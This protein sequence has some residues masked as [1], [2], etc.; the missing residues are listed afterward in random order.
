MSRRLALPL[1]LLLAALMAPAAAAAPR[2]C[3]AEDSH[4]YSNAA[5][6]PNPRGVTVTHLEAKINGVWREPQNVCVSVRFETADPHNRYIQYLIWNSAGFFFDLT[7][8]PAMPAG[9]PVSLGLQMP[10]DA[11]PVTTA[12]QYRDGIAGFGDTSFAV[13]GKTAPWT[14]VDSAYNEDKT[15]GSGVTDCSKGFTTF[16]STFGGF[17]RI[18]SLNADGSPAGDFNALQGTFMEGNGTGSP[19]VSVVRDDQRDVSAVQVHMEG[20]GDDDPSTLEGHFRAFVAPPALS[21]LGLPGTGLA[22]AGSFL[23]RLMDIRDSKRTTAV[24]GDYELVK[25]DDLAFEPIAGVTFPPLPSGPGVHGVI[26]GADF[27]Y[28]KHDLLVERRKANVAAFNRCRHAKRTPRKRGTKI[29]CNR[30]SGRR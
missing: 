24:N 21:Y 8:E 22:S 4:G 3:T 6:G 1:A 26:I 5:N 18:Q 10:A 27:S 9:T 15:A 11:K 13:Q 16:R 7:D 25:N 29:V 20:C 23:S 2:L 12:G 17:I 28:S 19:E 14:Y 30:V